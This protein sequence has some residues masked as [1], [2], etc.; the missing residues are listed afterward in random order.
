MSYSWWVVLVISIASLSFTVLFFLLIYDDMQRA[1]RRDARKRHPMVGGEPLDFRSG[2][3][4]IGPMSAHE[5]KPVREDKP[6][7]RLVLGGCPLGGSHD[8]MTM[9]GAEA[10]IGVCT[11]CGDSWS[12]DEAHE[13]V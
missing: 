5:A 9:P 6:V 1:R 2:V 12:I 7:R 11:R 10:P 13:E 4:I 8:I 3:R